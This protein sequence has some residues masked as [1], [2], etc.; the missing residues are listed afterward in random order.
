MFFKKKPVIVEA[1]RWLGTVKSLCEMETFLG[2]GPQ[3]DFT[4]NPPPMFIETLEGRMRAE[5]GD[6][7]IK[8]VRDEFYPCKPDIFEITYEAV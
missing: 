3:V 5:T 1:I 7:I 8:G 6:W 2:D 4:E